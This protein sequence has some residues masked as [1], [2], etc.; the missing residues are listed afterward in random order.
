MSKFTVIP[1]RKIFKDVVDGPGW[2]DVE[3]DGYYDISGK[4]VPPQY[5]STTIPTT[6]EQTE[7]SKS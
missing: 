4:Y 6:N 7:E 2:T 3:V 1:N 5:R